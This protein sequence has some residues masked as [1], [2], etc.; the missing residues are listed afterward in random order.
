MS[1]S[2]QVYE[3]FIHSAPERVFQAI[4]DGAQTQKY[5][6]G[7]AFT[8]SFDTGAT[9]RYTFPDGNTAVSGDIVAVTPNEMLVLTWSV[10]YDPR[11]AGEI[12]R[13]TWTL[14][15]KGELTKVTVT[16]NCENAPN[17]ANS[18]GSNGWSLVLS[19]LKTLLETGKAM[20]FPPMRG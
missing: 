9:F 2:N 12:S 19:G 15:P 11:C 14:E 1:Q 16:H 20:P 3:F 13:V 8:G 6:F 5:F 18:V 4:I 10:H 7:S 17:T